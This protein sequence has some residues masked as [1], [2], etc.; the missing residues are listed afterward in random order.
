[1]MDPRLLGWCRRIVRAAAA[2]VPADRRDDWRRE[3]DAELQWYGLNAAHRGRFDLFRRSAGAWR[4]AAA[5]R[6]EAWSL[7]MMQDI[8]YAIRT[9]CLRPG[10]TGVAV[11]TLAL[12]IGATTAIFSVVHGV[13]LRPLPFREPDRLVQ[14]WETNPSRNWTEA[15]IAP[16]NLVDWRERNRVFQDIA[17]YVGSDTRGASLNDFI[18]ATGDEAERLQALRVS[19]NFFDV[20]GVPA[21]IG[22]TFRPEESAPGQQNDVI[23][24][25][26][27]F[28]RQRFGADPSAVGRTLLL[29]G[30]SYTVVGVVPDEFK[31]GWARPDFWTPLA[32]PGAFRQL[33]VPHFLRA[34]ARLEPGVTL[35]QARAD[36]NRIA[37]ELE[38]E[39]PTS[40]EQMGAGLGPLDDWFV[41]HV[42]GALLIFLGAIGVVLLIA[43]ANVASLMLAR[44]ADRSREMAIR[45]AVG[46][47]RLRIVRQLLVESAVLAGAGA[48]IG[49]A[50]AWWVLGGLIAMSPPEVPRLDEVRIDLAVLAF[51]AGITGAATLLCGLVPA[52]QAGRIDPAPTLK[53]GS[54][55]STTAGRRSRRAIVVA[56]VAL[57]VALVA[58]AAVMV[59]SFVRLQGVDPGVDPRGVLTAEVSLPRQQYNTPAATVAF[60]EDLMTRLRAIPGVTAAGGSRRI[61]L[62]GYNVDRRPVDRG[63]GPTSGGASCATRTSCPGYFE[64]IGLPLLARPIV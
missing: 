11:A 7:D 59:R 12:A 3:W 2:I 64:A 10:Y 41:G 17:F 53:D 14:L 38:R 40:N 60:W 43:C 42:R 47:S 19:T 37:A 52:L 55:R 57:A 5:L 39:Y 20:L 30:T 21:M 45:T 23:V 50:L 24:L 32:Q 25:S 8:R 27:R 1:M 28:W 58:A 18:L 51:M 31:Y 33:R 54:Y 62:Q 35:A 48:A 49:V 46:A 9:L 15:T 4:H 29:G 22:R 63:H 13:L 56:E 44:A 6:R 61:A 16:A 34:V 36:L 26:E